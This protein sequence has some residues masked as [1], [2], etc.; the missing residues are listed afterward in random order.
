MVNVSPYQAAMT[1]SVVARCSAPVSDVPDS[2]VQ[3]LAPLTARL[4]GTGNPA[5]VMATLQGAPVCVTVKLWPPI[6][7][8]AGR[9][10]LPALGATLNATVPG[11]LP[12]APDV[13]VSHA[14]LL[15]AVHG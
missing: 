12:F 3:E 11:P 15:D 13:T 4:A 5:G 10:L 2:Q 14:A 1:R 9:W 6:V 7:S 8:V